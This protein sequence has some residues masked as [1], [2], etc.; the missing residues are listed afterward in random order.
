VP[1]VGGDADIWLVWAIAATAAILVWNAMGGIAWA[2]VYSLIGYLAGD[3]AKQVAKQLS[4]GILI[5]LVIVGV[6]C[7]SSCTSAVTA[8]AHTRPLTRRL[9]RPRHPSHERCRHR[10]RAGQHGAA[11]HRRRGLRAERWLRTASELRKLRDRTA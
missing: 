10:P 4:H 5:A 2:T 9:Q 3:A 7:W 6:A 8:D 11:D 1:S